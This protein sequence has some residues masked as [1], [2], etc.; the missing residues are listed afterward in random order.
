MLESW[1]GSYQLRGG[2][3]GEGILKIVINR[4]TKGCPYSL[5]ISEESLNSDNGSIVAQLFQCLDSALINLNAPFRYTA[6][7]MVCEGEL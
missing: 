2:R 7:D 1:Y 4:R 6:F 5:T 3:C